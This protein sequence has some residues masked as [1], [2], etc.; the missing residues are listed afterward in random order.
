MFILLV[1]MKRTEQNTVGLHVGF[2]YVETF[3]NWLVYDSKLMVL[4][5]TSLLQLLFLA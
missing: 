3:P 4:D 1:K 2:C 5:W